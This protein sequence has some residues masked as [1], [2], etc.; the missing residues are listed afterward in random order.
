MNKIEKNQ[1]LNLLNQ[2]KFNVSFLLG[3]RTRLFVGPVLN[4]KVAR[5]IDI[6]TNQVGRDMVSWNLLDIMHHGTNVTLW[7]GIHA[8]LRF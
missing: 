2:A 3:K 5:A 1:D 4:V 8:G 6:Q 7:P